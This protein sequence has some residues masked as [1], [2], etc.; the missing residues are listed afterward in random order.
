MNK[1]CHATLALLIGTSI[2]CEALDRKNVQR[3]IAASTIVGGILWLTYVVRNMFPNM[4]LLGA[5]K[6]MAQVAS[7]VTMHA[8]DKCPLRIRFSNIPNVTIEEKEDI[9]DRLIECTAMQ[10]STEDGQQEESSCRIRYLQFKHEI[11]ILAATKPH[12]RDKITEIRI[13]LPKNVPLAVHAN[14]G[15]PGQPQAIVPCKLHIKKTSAPVAVENLL[16]DTVIQEAGNFVDAIGANVSVH[17]RDDATGFIDV[18]A[19][20]AQIDNFAQNVFIESKDQPEGFLATRNPRNEQ[21]TL[22]EGFPGWQRS[23]G[24]LSFPVYQSKL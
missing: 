5:T 20:K 16:G 6:P 8:P 9:Q 3:F 24:A 1:V 17:Q 11:E 15:Y 13:L 10:L 21:G 7:N 23:T 14:S 22:I 12:A 2:F 18:R 4:P 19:P